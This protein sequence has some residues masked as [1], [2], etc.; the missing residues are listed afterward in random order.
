M[1]LTY[2]KLLS[3]SMTPTTH[4]KYKFVLYLRLEFQLSLTPRYFHDKI[5]I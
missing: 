3:K 4:R 1:I 2:C 5:V